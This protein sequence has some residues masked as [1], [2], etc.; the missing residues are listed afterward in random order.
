MN[1]LDQKLLRDLTRMW[2]QALAVAMVIACAVAVVVMSRSLIRTLETI[3][4]DYYDQYRFADVFVQLKRAPLPMADRVA[5]I[6]GVDKIQ[7]RITTMAR[8]DIPEMIEPVN[9]KFISIP[10][11][12]IDGLNRI[13]LRKGRYIRPNSN[14]IIVSES[15]AIGQNLELGDTLN[16]VIHGHREAM[17]IVGVGLSPEFVFESRPGD[18]IPDN[19]RFGIIW[20]GYKEIAAAMDMDGAFNDLTL[21]LSP[22]ASEPDVIRAIDNLLATYGGLGAY[23][24]GHQASH[25]RLRDEIQQI[26]NV[27]KIVPTIFLCVTAF[28]LNIVMARIIGIQ[29]EQIAIL[30][31]FGYSSFQVGWHFIKFALVI[32]VLGS[33]VGIAGGA[34]LGHEIS[35]IFTRF[36]KFPFFHFQVSIPAVCAAVGIS[37]GAALLGVLFEVR[38]AIALPP[39]EAMR[40][41][42]PANFRP[43]FVE[44]LGLH[45]LFSQ[46]L[47]MAMRNIERKP[48]HS[49]MTTIGLAL[50]VALMMV[51]PFLK[52]SIHWIEEFSFE[53]AM[54]QDVIITLIEPTSFSS[55]P[56]MASLP[57]VIHAEPRRVVPAR[58]R[59]GIY[60]HLLAIT[61]TLNKSQLQ[62]VLDSSFRQIEMPPQ[63]AVLSAKL[64]EILHV[65]VG[66]TI[67][68]EILEGERPVRQVVVAGLV[69]DFAG[70]GAWMD[71]HAVNRMMREGDVFNGLLVST[72]PRHETE[73]YTEIKK[74]PRIASVT[75]K[76]ALMD[77]FRKT[78]SQ[79][80][81][82]IRI[83]YA[84]FAT[85]IAFGVV[86]NSARISL[87]ERGR[88]LATLRV[89]G[90]T[91]SETAGVLLSEL[92]LLTVV[93][94]P[95][96]IFFGN[97]VA[98]LITMGINTETIRMPK[99]LTAFTY[100]YAV[101]GVLLAAGI[102]GLFVA[103]EVAQLD[104]VGV[105][106]ARD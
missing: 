91:R 88:E 24:R 6:S 20:I 62:R 73:F 99:I 49:I 71:L 52:D 63:G 90:F 54:R 35:F 75:L 32:L 74:M 33:L 42:P 5:E 38:K 56:E 104:L 84:V 97:I 67:Q 89:I 41:E 39:A 15:F 16:A 28:L 46:V 29:R 101:T 70:T 58:L 92:A 79:N 66:D 43:A 69:H 72:D 11:H 98:T 51:G 8:L 53:L 47:R 4:D 23:G 40:P 60:S 68:A 81:N 3:R 45:A 103:R 65:K 14:E 100:S 83:I 9:A 106:K 96:G 48:G 17:T 57:G 10:E 50:A 37:G 105:L 34:W 61:G 25:A 85:V 36:F 21:S 80:L 26:T 19:R 94:L 93:A 22:S 2:G 77:G 7:P 86:Y 18:V 55:L 44:R 13:H 59:N 78:T 27:S 95:L 31:A 12:P 76:A 1:A 82:V 102:S 87:A 30:K 64:A